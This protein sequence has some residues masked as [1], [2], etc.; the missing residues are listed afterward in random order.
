M[1]WTRS[2][3]NCWEE[4]VIAVVSSAIQEY[5]FYGKQTYNKRILLFKDMISDL[6][7]DDYETFDREGNS[8]TF[9]K[10]ETLVERFKKAGH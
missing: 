9:P 5:F 6:G 1:I 2:K 8:L 7:I 4:Q 3:T 10:Y